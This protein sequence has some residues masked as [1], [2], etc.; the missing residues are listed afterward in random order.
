M[1]KGDIIRYDSNRCSGCRL[2]MLAC[3]WVQSGE[4]RLS[5]AIIRVDVDEKH[6]SR[7]MTMA[8]GCSGCLACVSFCPDEALWAEREGERVAAKGGAS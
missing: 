6:F 8:T 2:C 4:H 1:S 7:E 5:S 3:A